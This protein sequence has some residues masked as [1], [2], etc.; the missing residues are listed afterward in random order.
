MW[1]MRFSNHEVGFAAQ[2]FTDD[3]F[4][5]RVS[6]TTRISTF[7]PRRR[8]GP[9]RRS[10][11]ARCS[12]S[13]ASTCRRM[14]ECAKAGDQA[15]GLKAQCTSASRPPPLRTSAAPGEA[16]LPALLGKL[17]GDQY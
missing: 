15:Y 13:N 8:N 3:T 7:R 9:A 12:A 17:D 4:V 5:R 16:C 10:R 6:Q 14:S 2:H 11:A 1:A